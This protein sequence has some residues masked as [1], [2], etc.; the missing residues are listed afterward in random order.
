MPPCDGLRFGKASGRDQSRD[1]A[2]FVSWTP[3]TT[4]A[5]SQS[6]LARE[7]NY[8]R[9]R[10]EIR[11]TRL[12]WDI[13]RIYVLCLDDDLLILWIAKTDLP[14]T[15]I[16]GGFEIVDDFDIV[17]RRAILVMLLEGLQ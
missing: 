1:V 2:L 14:I 5:L 11:L 8:T 15:S 13:Y 16:D 6:P 4:S 7:S 9:V 10:K 3:S 12:A 17:S